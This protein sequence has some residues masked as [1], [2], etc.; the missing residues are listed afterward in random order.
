MTQSLTGRRSGLIAR[1]ALPARASPAARV[2]RPALAAFAPLAPLAPLAPIAALAAALA[3][4]AAA[5]A[6]PAA[7]ATSTAGAAALKAYDPHDLT[8]VW[9]QT[10]ARPFKSYPF[11]PEYEA[12]LK[13][14]QADEA[15]GKPFQ[16]AQDRCL[17]AGLAASMTTG[18]YPIE[19]FYQKGGQ[20]ILLQKENLGALYRVFLNRG[21]KSADELY[22]LFYGDS[23]GH[24]EGDVLVVDTISLG[25]TSALDLI[26]PHSDALHVIQRFH[27]VS[28]DTL[29][30]ELTFDDPKALTHP[31][32]GVAV[33]KYEPDWELGEYECTNERLGFEPGGQQVIVPRQKP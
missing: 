15:A 14:R 9:M 11:T 1:P 24:W 21:H 8:G 7:A 23:V 19:I 25:A 17:P 26:A 28:Y 30:D 6:A 16:V 33:F 29:E 22:P 32:S 4:P 27:R 5:S 20:E 31:V 13:Q 2:S 18:A 3:L 12:I 10:R